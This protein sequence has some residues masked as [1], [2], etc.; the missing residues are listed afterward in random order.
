MR[1]CEKCKVNVSIPRAQCPLCQNQIISDGKP[2]AEIFP[3]I[4]LVQHKYGLALRILMFI[5]FVAI[6]VCVTINILL[7]FETFWSL[8]VILGI[9][10]MWLSIYTAI[11][12]RRNISKNLLWQA[13]LLSVLITGI[14]WFTG[15]HKWSINFVVPS[16]FVFTMLS[17]SIVLLIMHRR[18]YDFI[19]YLVVDGLL[20][21]IPLIFILTGW[22]NVIWPSL[23][24]VLLS[25]TLLAAILIFVRNMDDELKKRLHF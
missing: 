9:A 23:V 20:G 13:V 24:C 14:D 5:S 3:E 10:G 6:T 16:I 8:I 11:K 19:I 7:P 17:N 2:E 18:A 25:L 1:H 4:P 22:A 21:L 15:W 12:K